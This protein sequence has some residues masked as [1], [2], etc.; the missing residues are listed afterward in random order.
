VPR[1]LEL[2]DPLGM[3]FPARIDSHISGI[4]RKVGDIFVSRISTNVRHRSRRLGSQ[5]GKIEI[6]TNNQSHRRDRQYH[7]KAAA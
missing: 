3:A 1:L 5:P 6:S 2:R 7:L 4:A